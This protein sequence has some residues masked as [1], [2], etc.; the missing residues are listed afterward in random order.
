VIGQDNQP[1]TQT[2]PTR[3]RAQSATE[4][5]EPAQSQKKE[6]ASASNKLNAEDEKLAA[7]RLKTVT[8]ATTAAAGQQKPEPPSPEEEAKLR[9]AALN[10]IASLISVPIQENM[11]F[12]IG[13]HHRIQNVLN[14]QPVIPMR[15]NDNWNLIARIITPIIYQPDPTTSTQGAFGFGDLNPT[16]F[17]APAKPGKWI[18]GAGPA[19]VLPTAASRTLGQGKFSLGPGVVVLTQPGKWTLGL[20]ANNVWSV[21]GKENRAAVNQVLFQYFINYNLK[22]GYFLTWQPTITANWR[23]TG[24]QSNQRWV[25]PFGGGVGR[26]MKLGNQPVNVG[27]QAYANAVRPPGTSPFTLRLQIAFLY[28]KKPKK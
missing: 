26:I 14:I 28:P 3:L 15:L 9:K 19:F 25:I 10:P 12:G 4:S 23:A 16:F 18:W 24:S 1:A 5:T 13:P 20:L 2:K 8:A 27:I 6:V 22:K 11:N 21:A 7:E 17:F